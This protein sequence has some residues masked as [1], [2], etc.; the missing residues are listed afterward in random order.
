[1]WNF[2]FFKAVNTNLPE[3]QGWMNMVTEFLDAC[4]NYGSTRDAIKLLHTLDRGL[5]TLG[6]CS[7]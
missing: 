1:M 7:L 3:H 4:N 2:R 5:V 6:P